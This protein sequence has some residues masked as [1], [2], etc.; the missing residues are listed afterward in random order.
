MPGW[1]TAWSVPAR[2]A[3][4]LTW[5]WSETP[6]GATRSDSVPS[7]VWAKVPLIWWVTP[8]PAA[9]MPIQPLFSNRAKGPAATETWPLRVPLLTTT[10]PTDVASVWM[11]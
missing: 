8:A 1:N 4:P 3:T 5:S 10:V 7:E 2:R 9:L 11:A 6:P